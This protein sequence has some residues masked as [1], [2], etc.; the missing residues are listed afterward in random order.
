MIGFRN[1]LANI[2][3]FCFLSAIAALVIF[4]PFSKLIVR[5]V[6]VFALV[7]WISCC[8]FRTGNNFFKRLIPSSKFNKYFVYFFIALFFSVFFSLNPYHS[9]VVLFNRY[10]LY[11]LIFLMG[12]AIGNRKKLN[13]VCSAFI[14]S[15]IL[16]GIGGLWGY[17]FVYRE[18]LI[19]VF[20]YRILFSQYIA[21]YTPFVW[22]CSL[23]CK[24]KFFKFFSIFSSLLLIPCLI[25]NGSRAAWI[26]VPL[27]I[28]LIYII[29]KRKKLLAIS[30][31]VFLLFA[32]FFIPMQK[33]DIFTSFKTD[34]WGNRTDLWKAASSIFLDYPLTGA[35]LGMYEKLLYVYGPKQGYSEGHIHLHSHNT[36]LEILS[37]TGIL[38]FSAFLGIL[39]IFFRVI[40]SYIKSD[41]DIDKKAIV[42]GLTAGI[43]ST[44][45]LAIASTIIIVDFQDAALFWLVLGVI[46][47]IC[48]NNY[49]DKHI[50]GNSCSGI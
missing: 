43:I 1:K 2:F 5:R 6:F 49:A 29:S 21:M 25:L 44:L 11:F 20:Y 18:R 22:I 17:F 37:E 27:S 38:G 12:S 35:G 7:F 23:L 28:L 34:T 30:F 14:S 31:I 50:A 33:R 36:Y 48:I 13:F 19:Y 9:Q 41:S 24:N 8:F 42:L 39:F 16:L 40:F 10:F 3:D 46:N 47:G 4:A 45:V 32:L 26:G 15:S